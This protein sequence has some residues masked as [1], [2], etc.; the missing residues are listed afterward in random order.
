MAEKLPR[1]Y[2]VR[3]GNFFTDPDGRGYHAGDAVPIEQI[4]ETDIE[5]LEEGKVIRPATAKE[6]EA[7]TKKLAAQAAHSDLDTAGQ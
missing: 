2:I 3:E 6:E 7:I 4:A 5:A 1:F